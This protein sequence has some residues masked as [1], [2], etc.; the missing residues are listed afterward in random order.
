LILANNDTQMVRRKHFTVPCTESTLIASRNVIIRSAKAVTQMSNN[1]PFSSFISILHT[2]TYSNLSPPTS[3]SQWAICVKMSIIKLTNSKLLD[4][5]K[6]N[7]C[8]LNS[9]IIRNTCN[10]V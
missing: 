3:F 10:T 4:P 8:F 9:H 6:I 1:F 2:H 7:V 5:I